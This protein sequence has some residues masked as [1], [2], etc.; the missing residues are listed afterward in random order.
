MVFRHLLLFPF[1][2]HVCFLRSATEMVS[3]PEHLISIQQQQQKQNHTFDNCSR[4]F[5][6]LWKSDSFLSVSS[7]FLFL[8]GQRRQ[9]RQRSEDAEWRGEADLCDRSVSAATQT[10]CGESALKPKL[11]LSPSICPSLCLSECFSFSRLWLSLSLQLRITAATS[12]QTW[13]SATGPDWLK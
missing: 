12:D 1:F 6:H 2:W 5:S 4:P 7:S 9:R 3:L 10:V 8:A 11:L 13:P